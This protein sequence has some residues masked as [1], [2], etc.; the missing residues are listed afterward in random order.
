MLI[1]S[2]ICLSSSSSKR[3]SSDGI[4]AFAS[5]GPSGHKLPMAA[6]SNLCNFFWTNKLGWTEK[7]KRNNY[8]C[9]RPFKSAC[10][11]LTFGRH[12]WFRGSWTCER[13]LCRCAFSEKHPRTLAPHRPIHSVASD[14]PTTNALRLS[15]TFPHYRILLKA[16]FSIVHELDANKSYS[17]FPYFR[18][19]CL[20]TIHIVYLS[21]GLFT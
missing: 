1:S 15:S 8:N 5:S 18:L 17:M 14:G 9:V 2:K 12:R 3:P 13:C 19:D 11:F 6:N 21:N 20:T 10:I 4:R 16:N 7:R